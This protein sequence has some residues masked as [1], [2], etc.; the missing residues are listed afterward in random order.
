[1]SATADQ[2]PEETGSPPGPVPQGPSHSG[3]S[4]SGGPSAAGP[5]PTGHPEDSLVSEEV[6]SEDDTVV[7]ADVVENED[8]LEVEEGEERPSDL[9]AMGVLEVLEQERDEYLDRL[10]RLQADFENYKKRM[11]RLQ[12]ETL[13]RAG[14]GLATK[15]L[16][17]LDTI[18][19]ARQH[20]AGEGVDQ[21]AN[22]LVDVLTKEGLERIDPVGQPFDPNE[23]ESVSHEPADDASEPSVSGLMRAGYRWKGRLVRAAM[24][25][26]RG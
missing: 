12:S 8:D 10:Q 24:V 21:I 3:P 17:V 25:T 1:M 22:A 2:V 16:P 5:S 6:A 19:L 18:D 14:E 13:D 23:H 9:D 15:L 4:P 26:V 7:E 20:G 11:Q